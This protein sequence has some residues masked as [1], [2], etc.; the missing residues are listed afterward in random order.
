[1]PSLLLPPPPSQNSLSVIAAKHCL[2]QFS[3]STSHMTTR[4]YC[5]LCL[6]YLPQD[7]NEKLLIYVIMLLQMLLITWIVRYASMLRLTP[8]PCP[9][10]TPSV[11]CAW[12]VRGKTTRKFAQCVSRRGEYFLLSVMITGK[13]LCYNII[14]H[15][16]KSLKYYLL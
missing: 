14:I 15:C 16:I 11:N 6:V 4:M 3:C 2:Q 8:V 9:V 13:K 7:N 1:M 12:L 5:I 10:G